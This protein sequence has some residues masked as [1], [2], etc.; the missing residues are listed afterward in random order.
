MIYLSKIKIVIK[1]VVT[2]FFLIGAFMDSYAQQFEVKLFAHRGGAYETD[3]NTMEAFQTSYDNGLRGYET[4]VRI[5]KDGHLV[6]FHDDTFKR[7][8]G[9]DGGIEDLTL[10][11]VKKL[12]TKKG[13]EIPTVD[14]FLA[15][16]KDKDHVYIEFE[17]KTLKPLYDDITLEKYCDDL[18]KK[19]QEAKP[20]HS[21]YV[22]TSFDKRP[23]NYL[24]IKYPTV[25]LLYIKSEALSQSVLN[26]AKEMGISRV[27]CRAE[28]TTRDMV[29]AAKKQGFKVSLWPGRTVEDFL[30][31]VTLGSDYLCSDVPVQVQE[32]VNKNASS[33]IKLK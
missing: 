5:T 9:I 18:Y 23:L 24:K 32:W 30:L 2:L 21:D 20:T 19:I 33:W 10:A 22:M 15:F 13:N 27:G 8:V 7:I 29:A 11:Q 1:S 14:E 28:K 26:E 6:L 31:G 17:M 4:D 25:D 12:R 16:F 3:E